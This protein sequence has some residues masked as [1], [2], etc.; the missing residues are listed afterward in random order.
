MSGKDSIAV[1]IPRSVNIQD[2]DK[3]QLLTIASEL[4]QSIDIYSRQNK[5]VD[6][7]SEEGERHIGLMHLSLMRDLLK[8]YQRNGLYSRRREIN[9]NNQGKPNWK[10]TVS[11]MMPF[12]SDSGQPVYMD[13]RSSRKRYLSNCEVANIQAFILKEIDETLSWTVTGKIGRMAPEL[14]EIPE[15]Q[16]TKDYMV[17]ILRRELRLVYSDT[18]IRLI[19]NLI[20]YIENNSGSDAG[21]LVAGLHKF[22]HAWGICFIIHWI[23][24]I[25]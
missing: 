21:T 23:S 9:T 22:Q 3:D 14:A 13:Y 1:F 25:Q 5:A 4:V 10:K 18:D 20:A 11:S 6:Y 17:S 12:P 2:F 15:P 8:T 7:F 16:G 19:K 24:Y